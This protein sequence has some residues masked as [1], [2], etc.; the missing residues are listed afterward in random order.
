MIVLS[1]GRRQTEDKI[2]ST[3]QET[4]LDYIAVGVNIKTAPLEVLERLSVPP[5]ELREVHEL[6]CMESGSGV[7]IST[8]NRAEV[9]SVSDSSG[10]D[11]KERMLKE[12]LDDLSLRR[13]LDTEEK[14][15]AS[16]YAFSISGKAA[17]ERLFR[18]IAG[19][20]SVA[21]GETQVM[22]QVVR[23]LR[24]AGEA[25]S[26]EPALSRL[27]HA[28]LRT[29]RHI[30]YK[31]ALGRRQTSVP[32]LGVRMLMD[33]DLVE[34]SSV[35]LLGA[36]ETGR[37]AALALRRSGVRSITIASRREY[38]AALLA[39][40]LEGKTVRFEDRAEALREVD[41]LVTCTAASEPVICGSHV[42][43]AIENRPE[44]RLAVLDLGMP[45]DVDPKAEEISGVT[46]LTIERLR[47][48][49]DALTPEER[50]TITQAEAIINEGIRRFDTQSGL[51]SSEQA[52]K[53]LY[54]H[55][56]EVR[57]KEVD[58]TVRRLGD[59]TDR[60]IEHIDVMT[61]AIVKKLMVEP[62]NLM[63]ARSEPKTDQISD[64]LQTLNIGSLE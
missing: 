37:L 4:M 32:A 25:R 22:G 8:C 5:H 19:L 15:S 9:Y 44:R 55:A 16:Q 28:A 52:R 59:L 17:V 21:I 29:G 64:Y 49:M 34:G 23:S 42:K 6:L 35:L 46:L 24:A 30:H 43:S 57:R 56:E 38:K 45:R 48:T 60:Q 14:A 26:V 33:K 1:A 51:A 58:F 12:Y 10:L 31:T 2:Y 27:F 63:A 36:G 47:S 11:V 53:A 3:L 13:S 54:L 40:E 7:L 39:E 41:I 18:V 50:E 61:R 20:E 62:A